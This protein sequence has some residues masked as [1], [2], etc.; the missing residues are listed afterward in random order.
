MMAAW[1][2]DVPHFLDKRT[3]PLQFRFLVALEGALGVGGNLNR[4]SNAD[5]ETAAHLKAFYK[6]IRT[7][8][9]HGKPYRLERPGQ[10]ESSQVQYVAETALNP[11][12]SPTPARSTMGLDSR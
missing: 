6:S 2:T 7:T 4:W 5:I 11:C 10:S 3:I 9:E 8:V 1:V 12:C